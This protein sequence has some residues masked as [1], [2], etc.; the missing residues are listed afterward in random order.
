M[1]G[2]ILFLLVK[3]CELPIMVQL[4]IDQ[5]L[6]QEFNCTKQKSLFE[7]Q[8]KQLLICDNTE[9]C[10]LQILDKVHTN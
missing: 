6:V 9:V 5:N 8:L 7:N 2:E 4:L 10:L 3:S 1:L